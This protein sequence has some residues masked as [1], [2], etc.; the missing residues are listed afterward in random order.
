MVKWRCGGAL[1]RSTGGGA[2]V[3]VW[4]ARTGQLDTV[5]ELDWIIQACPGEWPEE[6]TESEISMIRW[7]GNRLALGSYPE[8]PRVRVYTILLNLQQLAAKAVAAL[9]KTRADTKIIENGLKTLDVPEVVK[10]EVRWFLDRVN[11]DREDDTS[12]DDEGSIESA[13]TVSGGTPPPSPPSMKNPRRR[14]SS[15]W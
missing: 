6:D 10:T 5:C 13:W 1:T 4:R 7:H 14:R 11:D 2:E 9:L 15:S 3:R 8:A 12:S